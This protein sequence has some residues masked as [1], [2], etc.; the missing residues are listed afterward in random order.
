MFIRPLSVLGGI[1]E[2]F[3]FQFVGRNL[4]DKERKTSLLGTEEFVIS[5]KRLL[6]FSHY[7]S[8]KGR[9]RPVPFC[10]VRQRQR[11]LDRQR[12]RLT[13]PTEVQISTY[14]TLHNNNNN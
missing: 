11:T 12:R 8:M 2:F 1:F 5:E 6:Y 10:S 14:Y 9:V 13:V 4:S 3:N 7:S